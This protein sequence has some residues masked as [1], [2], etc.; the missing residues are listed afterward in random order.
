MFLYLRQDSFGV[1][2]RINL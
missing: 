1:N 2:E